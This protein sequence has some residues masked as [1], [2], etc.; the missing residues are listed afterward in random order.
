MIENLHL[1]KVDNHERLNSYNCEA[2][3]KLYK[4]KFFMIGAMLNR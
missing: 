1:R 2:F 4:G 3:A